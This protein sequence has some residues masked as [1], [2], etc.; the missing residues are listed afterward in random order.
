[1]A[2]DEKGY[3]MGNEKLMYQYYDNFVQHHKDNNIILPDKYSDFN[4]INEDGFHYMKN[5]MIDV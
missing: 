1:M 2:V 3:I 5:Y 4:K